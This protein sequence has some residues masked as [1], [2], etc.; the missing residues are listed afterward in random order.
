MFSSHDNCTQFSRNR[1][2][3]PVAQ[4][5]GGGLRIRTSGLGTYTIVNE[6]H[7]ILIKLE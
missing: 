6:Y 3:T 5:E 4:R 1:S 7:N 2:N